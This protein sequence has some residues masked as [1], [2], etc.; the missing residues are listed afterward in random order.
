MI[1]EKQTM[2]PQTVSWLSE[3][4]KLDPSI[5]TVHLIEFKKGEYVVVDHAGREDLVDF[6]GTEERIHDFLALAPAIILGSAGTIRDIVGKPER[7]TVV[8]EQVILVYVPLDDH[9]IALSLSSDSSTNVAPVAKKVHEF[10]ERHHLET[11]VSAAN[12]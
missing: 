5:R 3:I 7:I 4:A 2:K 12:H 8:Y 6:Y 10:A 9:V 1:T 11:K